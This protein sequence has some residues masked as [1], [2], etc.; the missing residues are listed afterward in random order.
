MT[1]FRHGDRLSSWTGKLL[2]FLGGAAVIVACSGDDNGVVP[3][4]DGGLGPDGGAGMCGG[5]QSSDLACNG[6]LTT[7]CCA[8]AAA[9][10]NSSDCSLLFDCVQNC[11]VGD[12][13]CE[14]QC[15]SAN[16]N[17]VNA[18]NAFSNCINTKCQVQCGGGSSTMCGG[19]QIS[20]PQCSQCF[21][22]T[23]CT[24]GSK[25]GA[26]PAC[27]ALNDCLNACDPDAGAACEQAC[28]SQNA[29]GAM[30][31]K[32]LG[33]CVTGPCGSACGFGGGGNDGG[34]AMCGGFG[35]SNPTCNTCIQGTCCTQGSTCAADAECL[36]LFD[37]IQN[38]AQGDN[39]CEQA[40]AKSHSSGIADYN[41]LVGCVNNMCTVACGGAPPDGG[42]D[43]GSTDAASDAAT[44]AP[45]DAPADATAD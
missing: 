20:D 1:S 31:Y 2:F 27:V 16:P 44:D 21:D 23:C 12:T 8:Q 14:Q 41:A 30:D 10:G 4:G 13:A 15:A 3:G 34:T 36:A 39:A 19:F 11:N 9:C 43:A 28:Q 40:C 26:N 7:S 22:T 35:S 42:T 45:I 24:Q 6:C 32:A 37:C 33:D 29:G 17:G 5:F 25:C 38:C 18:L